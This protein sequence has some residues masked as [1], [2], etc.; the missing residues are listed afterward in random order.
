MRSS[1]FEALSRSFTSSIFIA[2]FVIVATTCTG[3]VSAADAPSPDKR[4]LRYDPVVGG[5][6]AVAETD[7]RVGCVYSHFSDRLQK[8]VWAI[9]QADGRFSHALGEGTTQSGWALDIRDSLEAKAEKLEQTDRQLYQRIGVGFLVYFQLDKDGHWI[10]DP[11]STHPSVYDAETMFRWE[12]S[13]DGYARVSSA[14]FSYRWQVID[15]RYIPLP[16]PE[17]TGMAPSTQP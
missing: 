10:L 3:F 7:A 9:W 4:I 15:G 12:W 16:E 8:R 14:P 17:V 13:R 1:S 5:L 2:T 6:V 11:N